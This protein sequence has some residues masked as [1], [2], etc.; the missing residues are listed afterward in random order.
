MRRH[1]LAMPPDPLDLVHVT[2]LFQALADSTRLSLLLALTDAE[3]TV[4]DLSETLRQPQSTVSRHLATL[5]HARLVQTRRDGPRV[6]YR[7]ADAHLTHLLTEAFSH[8]QHA[9]LGLPDHPAVPA[10]E[11]R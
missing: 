11:P 1:A 5:R 4:T 9:R 6:Y 2:G 7:L 8:A 3:R 10:G